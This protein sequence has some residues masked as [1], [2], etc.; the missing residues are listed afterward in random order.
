MGA[1][2]LCAVSDHGHAA[3]Y[4]AIERGTPV[5]AADGET[6][7]E[8]V[9]VLDNYRERILDGIVFRCRDGRLRF[10]DAPEVERTYERAVYL[11]LDSEAAAEL[12]PPP[13][14]RLRD[15][16]LASPLGRLLRRR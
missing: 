8:V 1:R 13:H 12:G 6:V 16:L 7:G 15:A 11:K 9:R 3:H 5:I 14:G 4:T 10:V 2:I